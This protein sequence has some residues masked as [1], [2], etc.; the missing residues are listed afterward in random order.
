[1]QISKSMLI[2]SGSILPLRLCFFGIPMRI[3]VI[4]RQYV[5]LV[6]SY[7]FFFLSYF[8]SSC[9]N[10]G[11]CQAF[12]IRDKL[13]VIL[14]IFLFTINDC[15]VYIFLYYFTMCFFFIIITSLFFADTLTNCYKRV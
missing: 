14:T 7:I 12:V 9:C 5:T 1:M 4:L 15:N 10:R 6:S 2:F 13:I 8:Q 3:H 11:Q